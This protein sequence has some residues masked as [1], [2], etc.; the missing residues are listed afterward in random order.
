MIKKVYLT[1]EKL[2]KIKEELEVLRKEKRPAV[3]AKIRDARS[4]GDLS[5]NAEYHSAREEQSFVEGKIQD[6]E[7]M[8]KHAELINESCKSKN[9][10]DM[11][12]TIECSINGKKQKFIIVGSAE[13][14]I[15]AGK[16]S[17]ESP[18][19]SALMGKKVGDKISVNTPGGSV[20]YKILSIK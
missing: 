8:I 7:Y 4:M 6:F 15:S 11:G 19:G 16:I 2:E 5:E 12:C 10:V 20:E 3:I 1:K 18:I 14:D 9:V 13:V 17:N